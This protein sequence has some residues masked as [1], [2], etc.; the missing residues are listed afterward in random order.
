MGLGEPEA[1]GLPHRQRHAAR[2]SDAPQQSGHR[3]V[4][5]RRGADRDP[6]REP[7]VDEHEVPARIGD[8][9]PTERDRGGHDR[10]QLLGAEPDEREDPAGLQ[11]PQVSL[12]RNRPCRGSS[13]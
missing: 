7:L 11:R 4:V 12:E 6:R 13:R 2:P 3:I 9:E 1:H 8:P 5:E 10:P